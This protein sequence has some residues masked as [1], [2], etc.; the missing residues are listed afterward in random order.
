[1]RVQLALSRTVMLGISEY[2]NL[3]YGE[4]PVQ[5][6]FIVS[7]AY[8]NLLSD[9]D[10]IDWIKVNLFE[11]AFLANKNGDI[12]T[13]RKKTTIN[14]EA[15]AWKGIEALRAALVDKNTFGTLRLYVP[16]VLKLLMLGA[17]LKKG[18][19]LPYL[20]EDE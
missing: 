9:L 1:M 18:C 13:K 20:K 5:N 12:S 10:E 11:K 3:M 19:K 16:F 15:D 17:I 2:R 7:L 14:I 6:G 8:K 4:A